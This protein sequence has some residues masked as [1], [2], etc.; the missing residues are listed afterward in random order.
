MVGLNGSADIVHR[1][2]ALLAACLAAVAVGAS[3]LAGAEARAG[4]GSACPT[5]LSNLSPKGK[6]SKRYTM[7]LRVN[8][9][10][11]VTE[12]AN[13]DPATGGLQP[14]IRT[15]DIFVINTRFDGSTPAEWVQIADA[16]RASFPCN[17][18]VALNGLAP[19]PTQPGYSG[20]LADYPGLWAL[21]ID[22]E[23]DDWNRGRKQNP[24]IP[25]WTNSFRMSLGR[26]GKRLS[27]LGAASIEGTGSPG[28]RAGVVPAY[29]SAWDYGLIAR[30][31]DRRNARRKKGRRGFQVVQTQGYCLDSGPGAFHAITDR[32]FEQYRPKPRVKK[33]KINGK[34]RKFKV[35]VPPRGLLNTLALEISFSNTPDPSD[36]RPVASLPPGAAGKCTRLSLKRGGSAYL[37]WAHP[38]SIRALLNTKH[39][40]PLR[41]SQDGC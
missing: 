6:P 28:R 32:L 35:K 14:R 33:K 7:L 11:N 2:P 19:D 13:S 22:W 40:C 36:P 23:Q 38:D 16:L 39:V 31:T 21:S 17:R 8:K 10:T 12:Y 26:I 25:G 4:P 34:L 9:V 3:L 18:I 37:Y 15:R 27:R 30:T 24:G 20:A 41:P 29:Y 5:S 1:R